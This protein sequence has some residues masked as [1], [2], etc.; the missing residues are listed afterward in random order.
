MTIYHDL[1]M[2]MQVDSRRRS[3]AL[4]GLNDTVNVVLELEGSSPAAALSINQDLGTGIF[5]GNLQVPSQQHHTP[6]GLC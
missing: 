1:Q 6:K 5:G 3:R 2:A 4:L